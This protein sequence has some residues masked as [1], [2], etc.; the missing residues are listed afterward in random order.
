MG[1]PRIYQQTKLN[2][3]SEI[4]L[5][6][7]AT[8]HIVKALRLKA[9]EALHLF[10]GDGYEYSAILTQ[11]GKRQFGALIQHQLPGLPESH[12]RIT[13]AQAI[14][15]GEKM[16][17]AIQKTVE[18]G[19]YAI[20]PLITDHI[21][22]K[23]TAD[24]LEKRQQHWQGVAISAAEQCGRCV[25]PMVYPPLELAT[26]LSE[27]MHTVKLILDPE[28]NQTFPKLDIPA[29][30]V[31]LLIGPEGGFSQSELA[32]AH[33]HHFQSIRIGP[34]ILRTETAAACAV[35]L[36]QYQWGDFI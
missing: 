22:I 14:S 7:Y 35:S 21:A 32:A 4:I 36:V 31:A 6:N 20:Q 27:C 5:D 17:Y 18:L 3:S 33:Q 30:E 24:V 29:S 10:N 25:V 12:C 2:V 13:L 28:A 26:W 15:R 19:V 11:P 9:G 8:Q 34:R 16:D 1:I 23:L